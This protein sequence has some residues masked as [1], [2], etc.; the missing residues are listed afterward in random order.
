MSVDEHIERL[1]FNTKW[2]EEEY[3]KNIEVFGPRN[4]AHYK[5]IGKNVV[6]SPLAKLICT[7]NISIGDYSVIDDFSFICAL[8]P[9]NI[10][11]YTHISSFVSIVGEGGM[12]L[13]DHACLTCGVRIITSSADLEGY[14]GSAKTP[15]MYRKPIIG[16]IYISKDAFIGTNAI[17][18]PGVKIGEG[19]V[20][21]AGAIA[22]KDLE[23]W[24]VY[25]GQPAKPVKERKRIPKELFPE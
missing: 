8:S 4:A 14:H 9:V 7:E 18:M 3:K 23:P 20:L 25:M 12:T 24:T 16:H 6:I 10:G 21:A 5:H 22:T 2:K 15:K 17:I 19:A 11:K 1:N 13:E